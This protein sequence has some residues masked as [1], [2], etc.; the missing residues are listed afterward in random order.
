MISYSDFGAKGD[1]KTDDV[2]A[3]AATH[4]FA[5]VYGTTIKADNEATYPV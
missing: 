2:N 4:A 1:G 5:N 3:I